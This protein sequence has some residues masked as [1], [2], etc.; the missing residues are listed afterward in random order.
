MS[1]LSR[2]VQIT[3]FFYVLG[4]YCEENLKLSQNFKLILS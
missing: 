2:I 4:E 3:D 1:I